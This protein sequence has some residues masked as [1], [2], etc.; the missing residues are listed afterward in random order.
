MSADTT[1]AVDV[2]V[3]GGGPSGASAAIFAARYG[4]DTLVFDRGPAALPRSAFL[5]NYPGFPAGIDIET[6]RG[7]LHDHLNEAGADLVADTVE[8][9]EHA[10]TGGDANDDG[11]MRFVVSTAENRT[12]SARHV[13]AASWYDGDY[14]RPLVG[15]EAYERHEHDGEEHEHFD[16]DYPDSDG[17]TDVE[18]LYVAAPAG[19]RNVQAVIAAGQGAHVARSLIKDVRLAT[20][21][22]AELAEHYDWLRSASEFSGDWAERGRWREWFDEHVP[23]EREGDADIADLREAYIDAAFET[24]RDPE[25]VEDLRERAHDR[26]L[27]HLDDERI[28]AYVADLDETATTATDDADD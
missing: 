2:V 15:D 13:V 4:L 1:R 20:G 16:G 17:R 14:L 22:P 18:G 12:V 7:L 10:A 21:Y 6:Y 25:T 27:E 26:L 8:M 23:A 19:Q 9:V 5:A 3:V 28:R 24:R 11:A